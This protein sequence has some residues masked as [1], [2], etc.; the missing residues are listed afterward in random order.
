MTRKVWRL[1]L[2]VAALTISAT[3]T[4]A[5]LDAQA[6]PLCGGL[7]AT[8]VG[9]DGDDVIEGTSGNDVIFAAQGNDTIFALGGDDIVC[10]GK[11]N[12]VVVGGQG[13]D[14]L[15]GA[16][17]DDVLF[18]ADGS[19]AVERADT[20]G[21]RIFGGAGNDLLIGSNRW[22]RMQG[23]VGIDHFEGYEGRDWIRGGSQTDYIDGG[24]GI[25]D[26]NG[27]N[28][29]DHIRSTT[30]DLVRGSN[31]NDLCDLRGTPKLLRSCSSSSAAFAS[32]RHMPVVPPTE[33]GV[34]QIV[35]YQTELVNERAN[36]KYEDVWAEQCDIPASTMAEWDRG[37][38]A[39]IGV[40]W[41]MV[42]LPQEI[43]SIEGRSAD[44]LLGVLFF[45]ADDRYWG[46]NEIDEFYLYEYGAWRA[47]AC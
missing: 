5:A 15:F 46:E 14:I 11:G 41:S 45:E 25:D 10:A 29:D 28:G 37:N 16:Q 33:S 44:V 34:V 22:D 43:R 1:R 17:G 47:T 39:A 21:A 38:D 18:A 30:D 8:I 6:A 32:A 36:L 4:P 20:R 2:T 3:M 13:F 9:T 12:D 23:G 19:S 42:F 26:M 24:G 40:G 31:G 35:N 27:G 7:A